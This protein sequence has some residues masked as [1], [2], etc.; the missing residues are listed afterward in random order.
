[1]FPCCVGWTGKT[2][3]CSIINS[4]KIVS[5]NINC[6]IVQKSKYHKT[7]NMI[8]P[9]CQNLNVSHLVLQLSLPNPLKL[10]VK[11]KMEIQFGLEQRQ[12]LLQLHLSEQQL[13]CL[14]R[15]DIYETFDGSGAWKDQPWCVIIWKCINFGFALLKKNQDIVQNYY[16]SN[17][18]AAIPCPLIIQT[19]I[20][21]KCI[22]ATSLCRSVAFGTPNIKSRFIKHISNFQYGNSPEGENHHGPSPD[23]HI[24][25]SSWSMKTKAIMR[26]VNWQVTCLSVWYNSE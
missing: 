2:A 1:M 22:V 20:L 15:C 7:S 11:S 23:T 10:S 3:K 6:C 21:I 8:R 13:C 25:D 9:K 24:N 19:H 16:I 18:F 17:I 12:A 14:L 5:C 4:F 26:S